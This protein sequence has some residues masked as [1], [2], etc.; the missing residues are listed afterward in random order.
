MLGSMVRMYT[1]VKKLSGD[2]M[3]IAS[4]GHGSNNLTLVGVMLITLALNMPHREA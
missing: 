1:I 3:L 2:R 4:Q